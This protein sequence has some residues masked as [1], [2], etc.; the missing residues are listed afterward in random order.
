MKSEVR[1][2][3]KEHREDDVRA[4]ALKKVPDGVNLQEALVQIAGWQLKRQ[5]EG[6][7]AGEERHASK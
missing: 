6:E 5:E 3:I 2:F 1:E 4:L 7:G